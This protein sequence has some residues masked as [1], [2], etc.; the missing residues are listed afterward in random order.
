MLVYTKEPMGYM[1]IDGKRIYGENFNYG[2]FGPTEITHEAYLKYK[3]VL[4]E[5]PIVPE[6]LEKRFG[7]KFPQVNFVYEDTYENIDFD[8]VIEIAKTLG[9]NYIKS[10]KPTR[11]EKRALRRAIINI[12]DSS[13]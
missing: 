4:K 10:F 6:W 13:H 1:S 11:S 12:I 8:T 7:K 9:I 3:G 5:A 2:K